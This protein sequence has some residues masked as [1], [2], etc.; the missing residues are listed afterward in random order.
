MLCRDLPVRLSW[1]VPRTCPSSTATDEIQLAT[2]ELL[3]AADALGQDGLSSQAGY[4]LLAIKPCEALRR[5]LVPSF[6]KVRV[7]AEHLLYRTAR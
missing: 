2:N 6:L 1:V 5:N 7:L 4:N 3:D